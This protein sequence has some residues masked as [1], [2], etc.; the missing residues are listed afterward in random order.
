ME[1][2]I[3]KTQDQYQQALESGM[4][5]LGKVVQVRDACAEP[6]VPCLLCGSAG[7]LHDSDPRVIEQMIDRRVVANPAA[8]LSENRGRNANKCTLLVG[9]S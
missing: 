2:R 5:V 4:S 8:N 9:E 6:C 3:I 1:P 7:Q